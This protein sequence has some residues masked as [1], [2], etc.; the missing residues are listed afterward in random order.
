MAVHTLNH[1]PERSELGRW[2]LVGATAGGISV[3]LFH[4]TLAA[5]LHAWG[6]TPIPAFTMHPT[7]PLGVPGLWSLVFWGA[8]W[9]AV[10]AASLGRL[11]GAA[12]IFASIAFGT[13]LPTIVALFV[14]APLKGIP[15]PPGIAILLNAAWGLG[16][17]VGL[18][19]FGRRTAESRIE[20]R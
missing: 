3:L 2:I 14:V 6:V 7:R 11:Q 15:I 1:Y 5:L 10:L 20:R 9:G 13:V 17:G 12:L 4:Q 19:W 8:V 18:Q 16:T